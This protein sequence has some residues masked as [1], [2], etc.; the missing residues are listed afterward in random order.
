MLQKE[1]AEHAKEVKMRLSMARNTNNKKK[2]I[3]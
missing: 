1:R 3:E 2:H